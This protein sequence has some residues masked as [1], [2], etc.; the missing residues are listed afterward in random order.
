[1]SVRLL[2][3]IFASG[4]L[5]IVSC[6][7]AA[8]TFESQLAEAERTRTSNRPRFD[9]I[10]ERLE[11][12][13]ASAT[14]AQRT[15]LQLLHAYQPILA[16]NYQEAIGE[17]QKLRQ[18]QTDSDVRYRA[19]AMLAN[20]Y[21][22]TGQFTDGL[23]VMQETLAI[24]KS[25]RN[26]EIR[27]QGI[28]A[29]AILYNQVG[30]YELGLRYAREI[31]NERASG[32][33]RCIAG[34]L[35]VEALQHLAK[36]PPG[37]AIAGVIRLCRLQGEKIPAGFVTT[38][39]ARQWFKEQKV[40]AAIRLL[41]DSMPEVD[42]TQYPRLIGETRSLMAELMLADGDLGG[43]EQQAKAAIAQRSAIDRAPPLVTAY[44]ILSEI[45]ERRNQIPLALAYFKRYADA[46]KGYLNE[47]KTREL[48]YQIV[49]AENQQKSQ[50][51]ELLNRQNALLQL[52]QRVDQQKAANSRLLMLLF[53]VFTLSV[54]YWGYKTRRLHAS[55]RHVAQTDA[56]TGICNRHHFTAQAEKTLTLCAKDGE[57]VSLIM[58]DLDHFKAIND[59]YGHVTGDWV[60]KEVAQACA[61]LCRPVDYFG[62]LGGEEFAILL[63]GCDLRAA[64]RIAEDCRLRI[65]RI[66]TLV[67]G[68]TFRIT[69]SCGVSC[70]TLAGY[71]LDVL[72]SQADQMLYRAKRD[73]RNRVKAY[74]HDLPAEA[75]EPAPHRDAAAHPS[76]AEAVGALNA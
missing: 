21:A 75:R 24:T 56:L 49:R 69:A 11:T 60:L 9:A 18:Q 54:A 46:E 53:A 10:L 64:T 23:A 8:Q 68:H 17:L 19:G 13:S 6:S 28:L 66:Q 74:A 7:V 51:I 52:Q 55:L 37:D 45:A 65:A 29:A 57:Q 1:M 20:S 15:Q 3:R 35:Q 42:G 41:K 22:L 31:L 14:P 38:F 48:A 36:A 40:D 70:T 62:R 72:L 50:Q 30:Q 32:R 63:H 25:V 33:S 58:F 5:A 39:L 59:S 61:G 71:N 73:G 43:A 34:G 47:A 76:G 2:A 67:S 27:Q 26:S 44:K 4:L 16:G 12:A